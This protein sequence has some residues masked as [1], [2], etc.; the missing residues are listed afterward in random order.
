[1]AVG[2]LRNNTDPAVA[3]MAKEIVNKWKSEVARLK[4]AK[5]AQQAKKAS[6][7]SPTT[8]NATL[9]SPVNAKKPETKSA[10]DPGKRNKN[11]DGIDYKV[12][13]DKV[14]DNCVGMLYDGLCLDGDVRQ[15]PRPILDVKCLLSYSIGQSSQNG[16]RAGGKGLLQL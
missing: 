9:P 16:D 7:A 10:V 15:C 2:K 1:M 4:T 6:T 13:G 12:T 8:A 5:G 14:R 11:T 3:N